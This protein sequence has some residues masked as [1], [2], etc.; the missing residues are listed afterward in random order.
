MNKIIKQDLYRYIGSDCNSLA[1]NY[2]MSFLC[3]GFNIYY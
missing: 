2:D 1:N 3:Q